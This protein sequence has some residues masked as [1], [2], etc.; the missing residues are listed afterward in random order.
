MH[1]TLLLPLRHKWGPFLQLSVPSTWEHFA[2]V[3]AQVHFHALVAQVF[4]FLHTKFCLLLRK[5]V[6]KIGLIERCCFLCRA[7]VRVC[8]LFCVS[9]T[10]YF[11]ILCINFT[12]C[13]RRLINWRTMNW[14]QKVVRLGQ[15]EMHTEFW[16]GNVKKETTWYTWA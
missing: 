6:L 3:S 7:C 11:R 5:F 15:M 12:L 8:V 4:S 14:A 10:K 13:R 1:C 2:C 9:L 16:C